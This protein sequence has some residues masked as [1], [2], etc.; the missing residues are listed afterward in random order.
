M[1][2]WRVNIP[3]ELLDPVLR[4]YLNSLPAK[5][6]SVEWVWQEMDRVW[7]ELDLCSARP[8]SSEQLGKFYGDPVWAMNGLFTMMDPASVQHRK[9]IAAY[10][11]P[12]K[13]TSVVD[14]GGGFGALAFEIVRQNDKASVFIV[15]PYPSPLAKHFLS[16]SKRIE[17]VPELSKS[18][19]YDAVISQDV[20]EHV[21]DPVGLVFDLVNS[22]RIG[23]LIIFANCFYPVIQCHLPNTFH[24][25]H[26]FKYVMQASGLQFLGKVPGAE[27]A[28]TF[29]K[30]EKLSI[31][32]GR[33]AERLSR[34]IGPILNIAHPVL[35]KLK[36][37]LFDR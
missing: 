20:L 3:E 9:S 21:Q 16:D 25:R 27:H 18:E 8:L 22:V 35:S 26:T 19:H 11:V 13:C 30:T 14:Y 5:Q 34:I 29:R 33:R 2:V 17:F 23:G 31:K 32:T 10:L 15:E 4:E 37:L 6:P 7:N 12:F 24:L 36:R 28:L 1:L